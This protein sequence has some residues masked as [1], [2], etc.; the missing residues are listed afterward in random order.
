MK[1]IIATG[2]TGG[3]LIPALKVAEELKQQGH[4]IAWVGTFGR[5]RK[6][7]EEQGWPIKELHARGITFNS[8]KSA[9]FSVTAMMKSTLDSYTY[10]RQSKPDVVFG[11]GGYGAFPVVFA[12]W[13]VG[14]KTIIHEQNVVPGRANALLAKIASRI[15]INFAKSQKYF[16][17]KKTIVTGTPC[18]VNGV[19][20]DKLSI[21]KKFNLDPL[22]LTIFVLG[23][24][25]GSHRINVEF[26]KVLPTI[27]ERMNLQAVHICGPQDYNEMKEKYTALN[28]PF[29]L[30]E[31]LEE[32]NEVYQIADLV[33][34][35]AGALTITEIT[36]AAVPAILIPYPFAGG[37]QRPN[38]L[39]LEE[40]GVAK[41]IEDKNL[42][43]DILEK[44]ILFFL[45]NRPNQE[46]LEKKLQGIRRPEATKNLVYEATH[47]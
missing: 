19:K 24:S 3:H 11:F 37:H 40:L 18:H 12:G 15:T 1:I 23:G 47:I 42:S 10:L 26:L 17:V 36:M 32:I 25:Q 27:K 8:A 41:M 5:W 45:K 20:S 2:G 13:L 39:V 21:Y 28:I 4:S 22:R 7:V 38:A 14:L 44:E 43:A 33:I 31:F 35:R 34:A 30:Y 29:A 9:W 6:K 16:P 46:D